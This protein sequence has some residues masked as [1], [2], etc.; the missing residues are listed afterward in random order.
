[1]SKRRATKEAERVQPRGAPP[2]PLDAALDAAATAAVAAIMERGEVPSGA[3]LATT[4]ALLTQ[5]LLVGADQHV[6]IAAIEALCHLASRVEEP[7]ARSMCLTAAACAVSHELVAAGIAGAYTCRLLTL[8]SN[9]E[10]SVLSNVLEGPG[11]LDAFAGLLDGGPLPVQ[12]ALMAVLD[13]AAAIARHVP[14]LMAHGSLLTALTAAISETPVTSGISV[15]CKLIASGQDCAV[16]VASVSGAVRAL[17]TAI[18]SS[19]PVLT[20]GAALHTVICSLPSRGAEG[21]AGDTAAMSILV[22]GIGS[23][24]SG[25]V[26]LQLLTALAARD[27]RC[28]LAVGSVNG[29][30]AKAAECFASPHTRLAAKLLTEFGQHYTNKE[31]LSDIALLPGAL[32]AMFALHMEEQSFAKFERVLNNM[33]VFGAP[34]DNI[35]AAIYMPSLIFVACMPY[36]GSPIE[37]VQQQARKILL[38]GQ[39]SFQAPSRRPGCHEAGGARGSQAGGGAEGGERGTERDAP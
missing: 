21:L 16:H 19:P 38:R 20:A 39:V 10:A 24:E 17:A 13:R 14:Q 2:L 36:L 1:M 37:A 7:A 5:S 33:V 28:A 27:Q 30:L 8:V 22:A 34:R 18:T 12:S 4:L 11:V 29:I 35:S 31:L 25:P 26:C 32:T 3:R 9:S 15:L 6:K 23:T